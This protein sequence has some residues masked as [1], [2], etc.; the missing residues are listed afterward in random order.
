MA[1]R[2]IPETISLT[3]RPKPN[4]EV[5]NSSSRSKSNTANSSNKQS[6]STNTK[7]SIQSV[8]AP[9]KRTIPNI[10]A[11]TTNTY[12]RFFSK[13]SEGGGRNRPGIP[14]I[15]PITSPVP[16]SRSTSGELESSSRSRSGPSRTDIESPDISNAIGIS[17]TYSL[18]NLTTFSGL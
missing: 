14:K 6:S 1:K 16:R 13:K 3:P 18:G 4:V 9:S 2:R 5:S 10:E 15:E 8:T 17:G 12:S 11:P 7:P